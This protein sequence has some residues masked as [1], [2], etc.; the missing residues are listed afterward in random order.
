MVSDSVPSSPP[1]SR[2]LTGRR[3]AGRV[4]FNTHP[5]TPQSMHSYHKPCPVRLLDPLR[6]V[7]LTCLCAGLF[8]STP[9]LPHSGSTGCDFWVGHVTGFSQPSHAPHHLFTLHPLHHCIPTLQNATLRRKDTSRAGRAA[10]GAGGA[11]GA[12]LRAYMA[13]LGLVRVH[14]HAPPPPAAAAAFG[15][16]Q[17]DTASRDLLGHQQQQHGSE[18]LVGCGGEA[19]MPVVPKMRS[20]APAAPAASAGSRQKRSSRGSRVNDYED[21]ESEWT[22]LQNSSPRG[23]ARGADAAAALRRCSPAAAAADGGAKRARTAATAAPAAMPCMHG[24][25]ALALALQVDAGAGPSGSTPSSGVSTP[26]G[27]HAGCSSRGQVG[28]PAA[29]AAPAGPASS[30]CSAGGA[31]CEQQGAAAA[32]A[33]LLPAYGLGLAAAGGGGAADS[34]VGVLGFPLCAPGPLAHVSGDQIVQGPLPVFTL[35]PLFVQQEQL[36]PLAH[37]VLPLNPKH[38]PL[39][40]ELYPQQQQLLQQQM[41]MSTI[42]SVAVSVDSSSD[43]PQRTHARGGGAGPPLQVLPLQSASSSCAHGCGGGACPP[44]QVLPLQSV[45]SED[46]TVDDGDEAVSES[47]IAEL[48]LML[49]QAPC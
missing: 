49:K 24:V 6:L 13:Q 30:D 31:E 35:P 44:L 10:C 20:A 38:E 2:L 17:G 32:A 25:D 27:G 16:Q 43:V 22:P 42:G 21:S 37:H 47:Q 14:P 33:V 26:L 5:H 36:V 48:M 41:Q 11:A 45:G 28:S 15:V 46:A 39:F 34:G 29:A 18:A 9:L 1:L 40:P 12:I 3:T 4:G 23:G 7:K 19:G 8:G